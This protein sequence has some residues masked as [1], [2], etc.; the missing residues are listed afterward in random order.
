MIIVP[1]L[2]EVFSKVAENREDLE[3]YIWFQVMEK[4]FKENN[5]NFEDVGTERLSAL[6]AAQLVLRKPIKTSFEEIDKLSRTE[7]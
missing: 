7:D 3:G 4:I 6:K 1:C 2:T 5:Y